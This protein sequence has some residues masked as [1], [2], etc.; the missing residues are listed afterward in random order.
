M[1]NA[2]LSLI[3]SASVGGTSPSEL[4]D[5]IT[6]VT[7]ND[8]SSDNDPVLEE[9]EIQLS[10]NTDG[11]DGGEALFLAVYL[12]GYSNIKLLH[13][14]LGEALKNQKRDVKNNKVN[15]E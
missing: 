14:Y 4:D 7:V 6:S 10:L 13:S 15:G 8:C 3:A 11:T 2:S 1:I 12:K 5:K 9:M